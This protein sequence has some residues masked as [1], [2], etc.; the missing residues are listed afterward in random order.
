MTIGN[1]EFQDVYGKYH[2]AILRYLSRLVGRDEAEDV[3]QEVFLKVN[4]G[5]EGYRGDAALGTWIFA[6]ARNA[7]LD[8][9]RARR[10]WDRSAGENKSDPAYDAAADAADDIA[11]E[12]M[13]V[14]R[15]LI[16][17][18]MNQ[19]IRGRVETLPESYQS[20]LALS[21]LAGMTN[22]EIASALK[23]TEGAVKIRL[24]RARAALRKDLGSYCALYRDER[25]ELAC[26]P[27]SHERNSGPASPAG[28]AAI[29]GCKGR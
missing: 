28:G 27:K 21:E 24:H 2:P 5:L 11:D 18:E 15:R 16:A 22:A 13:S 12:Q 6:I 19:C 9:L 23:T 8:R 14:E 1:E 20:V 4:R 25:D 26:E 29:G 10:P 17:Q 7:A 3:A